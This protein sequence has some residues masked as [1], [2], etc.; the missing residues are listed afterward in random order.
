MMTLS[1]ISQ[2]Y[3]ADAANFDARIRSLRKRAAD[4]ADPDA[5]QMLLQR[6]TA[7]EPIL[8]QSRALERYT[9]NYYQKEDRKHATH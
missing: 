5:R 6:A 1:E 7:L 9:A 4:T 3:A 8:R 2:M